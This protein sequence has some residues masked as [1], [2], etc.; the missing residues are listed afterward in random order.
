[1]S[2][3]EPQPPAAP[4]PAPAPAQDVPLSLRILHWLGGPIAVVAGILATWAYADVP[5]LHIFGTRDAIAKSIAGALV[6]LASSGLVWLSHNKAVER[7][8]AW[9]EAKLGVKF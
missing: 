1:M 2:T 4:A 8:I 6:F 5:G 9:A 7:A 3:Q